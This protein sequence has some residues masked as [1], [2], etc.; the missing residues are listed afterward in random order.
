MRQEK[1]AVHSCPGH[2]L[3]QGEARERTNPMRNSK[4]AIDGKP[5]SERG[6]YRTGGLAA[7]V[8]ERRRRAGPA[9]RWHDLHHDKQHHG[10]IAG[11]R[12][13]DHRDAEVAA[14]SREAFRV[15]RPISSSGPR[16]RTRH[17][18]R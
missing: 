16:S 1:N 2:R 10:R 13:A 14:A 6:R 5:M 12:Q 9:T 17:L 8:K 18:R 7:E 3:H 11:A 4:S 15:L